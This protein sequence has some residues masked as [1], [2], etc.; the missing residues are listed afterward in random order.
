M[1]ARLRFA[2]IATRYEALDELVPLH[3]IRSRDDHERAIQVLNELLDGGGLDEENPL[4]ALVETLGALIES[5]E[6]AETPPPAATG[7]DALRFLM[8]QHA[9]R[10]SE[11]PEIGSQGVVS[12]ILSGR[13]ALTARHIAVLRDRFGVRADVFL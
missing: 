5:Y 11:L 10:Q 2:E 13:R 8:E 3:V 6:N 12:E 7:V 9:L 1:N 4:S